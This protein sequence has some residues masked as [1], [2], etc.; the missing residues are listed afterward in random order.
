MSRSRSP[1]RFTAR[2]TLCEIAPPSCAAAGRTLLR[3][4]EFAVKKNDSALRDA[5]K[6]QSTTT[7]GV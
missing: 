6:P 7:A 2:L 5:L 1:A 4:G 3:E